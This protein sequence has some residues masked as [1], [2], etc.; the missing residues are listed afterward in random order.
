M[1]A[2]KKVGGHF[3]THPAMLC[4]CWQTSWDRIVLFKLRSIAI[5]LDLNFKQ[6]YAFFSPECPAGTFG[7]NCT[8]CP[9]NHYDRLCSSICDCSRNTLCNPSKGCTE[10]PTVFKIEYVTN[11]SVIAASKKKTSNLL[12]L[13]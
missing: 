11:C 12:R 7:Y 10:I 1:S 8:K 3:H 5:V 13:Y 6:I 9:P 2:V 4:T